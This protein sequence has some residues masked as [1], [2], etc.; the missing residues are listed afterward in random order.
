MRFSLYME[1]TMIPAEKTAAEI[2]HLLVDTGADQIYSRYANKKVV[3]LSFTLSF[4]GKSVPFCLPVR[5]KPIFDH[6]QKK[7]APVY[8]DRKK[9]FD[10]EQAERVAWRQL[11][12]WV[13]A[14]LALIDTGMV[15]P[16]E[17]FMPYYEVAPGVTMF[18]KAEENGRLLTA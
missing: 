3:G 13:Q 14:Q 16:V 7:R 18:Q 10:L 6:L 17:V 4:Q 15:Q 8:R 5:T 12:R 2:T 11:Y 9:P 1:T